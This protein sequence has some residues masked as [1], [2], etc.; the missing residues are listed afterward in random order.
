MR[1]SQLPGLLVSVAVGFLLLPASAPAAT[2]TFGGFP[3]PNLAASNAAFAKR[4]GLVGPAGATNVT[5]PRAVTNS[6]SVAKSPATTTT[7]L[8]RLAEAFGRL[9]SSPRF[10]PVVGTGALLAL[11]V[12][13]RGLRPKQPQTEALSPVGSSKSVA[14]AMTVKS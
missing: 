14:R 5:G 8:G 9:K 1:L 3:R 4:L 7:P 10:Y 11:L 6:T 12:W 2:N 13:I